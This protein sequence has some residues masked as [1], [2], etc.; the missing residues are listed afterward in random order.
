VFGV[1]YG[2][3]LLTKETKLAPQRTIA[4]KVHLP[5]ILTTFLFHC[6]SWVVGKRRG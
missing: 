6:L 1:C 2:T 3:E 4:E 5:H